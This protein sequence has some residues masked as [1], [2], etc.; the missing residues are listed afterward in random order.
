MWTLQA[1]DRTWPLLELHGNL[2]APSVLPLL[3]LWPP[4]PWDWGNHP[5]FSFIK[6]CA[7][8]PSEMIMSFLVSVSQFTLL[9]T[10]PYHKLCYKE[11]HH[12]KCDV[13]LQFVR[14]SLHS[15]WDLKSSHCAYYVCNSISMVYHGKKPILRVP[16]DSNEQE[17]LDR[18][19]SPPILGSEVL[20]VTWA[21]QDAAL[22]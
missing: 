13:C 8:V 16:A 14:L 22:L 21:R 9:G 4:Y 5:P 19:Q 15:E 17:W 11:L 2:L 20:P 1:W 3:L 18:V 12:P 7:W 10:D 6:K